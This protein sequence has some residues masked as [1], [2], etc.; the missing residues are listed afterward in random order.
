MIRKGRFK[1]HA[2]HGHAP[3]LY[4]VEADPDERV[5][6]A[7]DPGH[8]VV[9]RELEAELESGWDPVDLDARVRESQVRRRLIRRAMGGR[10]GW[11]YIAREGDDR[12]FVRAARVDSTKRRSRFPPVAEVP[13]DRPRSRR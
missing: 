13:P 6:L 4:D 9:R 3:L 8:A 7:E 10:I 5:N 12:R 1:Y 11:D 2:M